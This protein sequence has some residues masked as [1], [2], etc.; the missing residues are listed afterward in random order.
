MFKSQYKSNLRKGV[1]L[2]TG[3]LFTIFKVEVYFLFA[4][5][6]F[7]LAFISVMAPI[8]ILINCFRKV[9][10]NKGILKNWIMVYIYLMFI[11]VAV[12][13]VYYIMV[14]VNSYSFTVKVPIYVILVILV[15]VLMVFFSARYI[16]RKIKS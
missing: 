10:G 16:Y 8:L 7:I 4:A 12:A 3:I 2:I 11:R 14:Q 1:Y 6:M 13:L 15:E 9:S 5:R